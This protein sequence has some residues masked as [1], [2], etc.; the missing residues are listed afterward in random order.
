MRATGITWLTLSSTTLLNVAQ[1]Q[2]MLLNVGLRWICRLINVD[3]RWTGLDWAIGCFRLQAGL[4]RAE[5]LFGRCLSLLIHV[6][7]VRYQL[8]ST[9]M[10]IRVE[11]AV[12]CAR[13]W[14]NFEIKHRSRI[15]PALLRDRPFGVSTDIVHN[16]PNRR[17][18]L[19]TC[20]LR[21]Y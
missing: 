18:S 9:S 11:S 16:Q 5:T 1:R 7:F 10:R 12:E 19:L 21:S 13:L 17:W 14:A 15:S 20:F 4:R 3:W 8:A 2:L 6:S